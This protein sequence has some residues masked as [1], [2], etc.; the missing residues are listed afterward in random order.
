MLASERGSLASVR[1]SFTA[2][3]RNIHPALE[4]SHIIDCV[5]LSYFELCYAQ[6]TS[7]ECFG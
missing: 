5:R 2:S 4:T 7:K 6:Q 3:I 1:T